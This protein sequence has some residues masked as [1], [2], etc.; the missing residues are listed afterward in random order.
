M[1]PCDHIEQ[2][3]LNCREQLASELTEVWLPKLRP[4]KQQQIPLQVFAQR[5]CDGLAIACTSMA[6]N[7]L[8]RLLAVDP[9]RPLVELIALIHEQIPPPPFVRWQVVL[10]SGD[11]PDSSKFAVALGSLF[12]VVSEGALGVADA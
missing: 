7:E 4:P 1:D 3:K 5:S 10:P 2:A 6:G 12:G 11:C 9:A 8:G